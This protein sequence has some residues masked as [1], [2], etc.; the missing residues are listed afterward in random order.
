MLKRRDERLKTKEAIAKSITMKNNTISIQ[1]SIYIDNFNPNQ[2]A[3]NNLPR[4]E[5]AMTRVNGN[6]QRAEINRVNL[7]SYGSNSSV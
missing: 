3:N 4:F 1:N 5:R 6:N 7:V 2:H